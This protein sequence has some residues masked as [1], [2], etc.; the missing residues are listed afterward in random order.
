MFEAPRC[1]DRRPL[2]PSTLI[3]R[4]KCAADPRHPFLRRTRAQEVPPLTSLSLG[5]SKGIQGTY[6]SAFC[7]SDCL[8]NRHDHLWNCSGRT[9][10]VLPHNSYHVLH[11]GSRRVNQRMLAHLKPI[12]IFPIC[13]AMDPPRP[14]CTESTVRRLP[15]PVRTTMTLPA[16]NC[17]VTR[18]RFWS[19][20]TPRGATPLYGR[21]KRQPNKTSLNY[22]FVV[23][24]IRFL[25]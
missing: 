12:S 17:H 19:L 3:W 18:R 23:L 1:A 10:A 24:S 8:S 20:R 21:A 13:T 16:P 9:T 15:S 2:H 14:C 22:F 5:H 25:G 6:R 7:A 4:P 11:N